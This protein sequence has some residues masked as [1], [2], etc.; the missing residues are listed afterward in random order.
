MDAD[1]I[2]FTYTTGLDPEEID[3]RIEETEAGVLSLADGDE[4]YAVPLSHYHAGDH[5]VFRLGEDDDSRKV[6]FIEATGT[7]CYVLFEFDPP[8]DSWSVLITGPIRAVED[9][10]AAGF[11]I[12]AINRRFTSLRVFD[13]ALDELELS[14]YALEIERVTGRTTFG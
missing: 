1:H 14:L 10:A 8:N 3:R 12:A 6:D 11:D 2:D 13:E 5:L 7:A 9:P 4:A